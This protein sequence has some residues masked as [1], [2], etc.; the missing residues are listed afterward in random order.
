M[1]ICKRIWFFTFLFLLLECPA[2][3]FAQDCDSI[4]VLQTDSVSPK[5]SNP[6]F[7]KKIINY[8][9]EANQETRH[10][11]FDFRFLGGPHY[12]SDTKLGLGLVAAGNYYTSPE[13]DTVTRV[14][15]VALYTDVTTGGFYKVGIRGNNFSRGNRWRTHY[16]VSFYSF[17]RHMWGI[18]F[19]A[20]EKASDYYKFDELCINVDASQLYNLGSDIYTGLTAQ[21]S[22]FKANKVSEQEQLKRWDGQALYTSTTSLGLEFLFDTRDNLTAPQSGYKAH[23]I[24][25]FSP[26]FLGNKYAYSGTEIGLSGYFKA[27]KHAIVAVDIHSIFNYGNVPWGMMASFGGS[28]NMRGYYEGRFRDKSEFDVTVELRQHVWRRNGV[29][30]WVGVGSVFPKISQI[31][32]KKLLPCG[33]IGYR[34]EFKKNTNVR[35]DYGIGRGETSFIFSLNEAF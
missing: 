27:W 10:D 25:R 16:N 5:K 1:R 21:Y 22:H 33:G 15:N 4:A 20:G 2:L 28:D 7:I 14:S 31:E 3:L 12:S 30:A 32:F 6:T 19:S 9:G 24:Q 29:V 11:G 18:G 17:L 34:W 35:L 23:I 26:R 8:F 13:G